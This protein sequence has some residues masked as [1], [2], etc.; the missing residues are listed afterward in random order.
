MGYALIWMEG[1]AAALLA[2]A[3]VTACAAHWPRRLGQRVVPILLVTVL[4]TLAVSA[5]YVATAIKF[6]AFQETDWFTY[7]LSWTVL[8]TIGAVLIL[9]RGLRA[10]KPG[11]V[12]AAQ[13]WSRS[14]LALA[15]GGL[16]LLDSITFTNLDVAMR[17][18]MAS[19]RAEAGAMEL[20]LLP[21]HIPDRENAA[22]IY[23]EAFE[24]LTPLAKLP[25]VWKEKT[26]AW[27]EL[28]TSKFDPKDK[29]L[30]EYLSSQ[31][32]GLALLRK[33]A[34]MPGCWFE[35]NYAQTIEML[36]PELEQ[37]RHAAQLLA[38][39][40]LT[41][42]GDGEGQAA[43]E[44]VAAIFGIAGHI[45]DPILISCLTSI[46]VNRIGTKALED[47]LALTTPRPEDLARLP[48]EGSVSYRK[49]LQRACRMEE[50]AI[51]LSSFAIL[52]GEKPKD[53][54]KGFEQA[55]DG[56]PVWV[57]NSA[58]WRVF[59]LPDD[60]AAYR[61]TM[62]ELQE[63]AARPYSEAQQD[64]QTFDQSLRTNRRGLLTALLI[65][66]LGKCLAAAAEGDS[67]RQLARLALATTAYRSKSRA[68]PEK[69]DDLVP[70]YLER[71]PLDPF[72]GQPLR[73]K[74]GE[75][76]LVLYSVG[77]DQKDDGGAPWDAAKQEGDLLFR[78]P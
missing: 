38:L 27:M 24:A 21:P 36:L 66:H 41:R 44:D 54:R 64:W 57:F 30:R 20:G 40:A 31:A 46:A 29:D 11:G 69:L 25:P 26:S 28:D 60:L 7:A 3:L 74:R 39:D 16:V 32:R 63:M 42:A 51:G 4:A 52:A 62:R 77:R 48:L 23:E 5:T 53:W 37:F 34:A 49:Y 43:A 61:R 72:D 33:A 76:G 59:F 65:P 70:E 19:V 6:G 12:S 35:R 55:F 10:S 13:A 17:V 75:R 1:M 47:T 15:L 8:F 9:R 50:A 71:I 73:M 68:Y 18:Q 67:A 78:L 56:A 45:N 2:V 22:L 58:T 14:K